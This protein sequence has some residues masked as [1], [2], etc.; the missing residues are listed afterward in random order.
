VQSEKDIRRKPAPG[1]HPGYN[2]WVVSKGLD[3][4]AIGAINAIP[5]AP[6]F[7]AAAQL[8]AL[9]IVDKPVG[10]SPQASP[11]KASSRVSNLLR[12]TAQQVAQL[13][14]T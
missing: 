2:G 14:V 10:T 8:V 6:V 3:A 7:Q 4:R 12:S 9:Q 1:F 5:S 11:L 13:S